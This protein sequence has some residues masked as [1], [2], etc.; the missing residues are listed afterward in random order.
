MIRPHRQELWHERLEREANDDFSMLEEVGP[1]YFT[2][3]HLQDMREVV[4][5]RLLQFDKLNR[6][7]MWLGGSSALWIAGIFLGLAFDQRIMAVAFCIGL[8]ISLSA[9]V[10]G[11]VLLKLRFDSRGSLEYTLGVIE[12]ELRRRGARKQS[13]APRK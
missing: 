6:L 3:E 11:N 8:V 4:C 7:N 9:F 2:A 10:T 5:T 13:G 1:T 12:E